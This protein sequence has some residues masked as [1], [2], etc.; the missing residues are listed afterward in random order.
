M[1]VS[2]TTARAFR[3]SVGTTLRR[4]SSSVDIGDRFGVS[5]CT[6]FDR[7]IY[8]KRDD[9]FAFPDAPH[10]TGNKVRKLHQLYHEQRLPPVVVSYGGVQSNAMRALAALC[11]LRGSSF[12]YFSRPVP[13]QLRR[14]PIGNFADACRAG[15][16]LVELSADDYR[17]LA[18][19]GQLTPAALDAWAQET[20]PDDSSAM[21]PSEPLF[22]SQGVADELAQ[23]GID[24]LC[25][26]I[27]A[28]IAAFQETQHD[29]RPWKVLFATGTGVSAFFAAAYFHRHRTPAEAI[30]L[31]CATSAATLRQD[32]LRFEHRLLRDASSSGGVLPT[33]LDTDP[34]PRRRFG[35]VYRE[36]WDLWRALQQQTD[37]PFDLLY[38]PR[39]WELLLAHAAAA[40][41]A[42][43]TTA[44]NSAAPS[45]GSA[46]AP[47]QRRSLRH[48]W[49]DHHVLYYHCGGCE[50]NASQL[51][52]YR[53][54]LSPSP[55][56]DSSV[57]RRP[58]R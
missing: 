57:T 58:R 32:L 27:A 39:A 26:D 23:A 1:V 24:R 13:E 29:P 37:M 48:L 54:L 51:P 22:V 11:Q 41:K 10:V 12:V 38:A 8:F 56:P 3:R 21:A 34:A 55:P 46:E 16:R 31:P 44:V 40:A 45:S 42:T 52:R 25:D 9:L 53:R 6:I 43:T 47:S 50:G 15:M 19:S 33:V 7:H 5:S 14:D 4:F 36:H 49:P 20:A 18:S 17:A 30:A 28:F 2:F 35:E